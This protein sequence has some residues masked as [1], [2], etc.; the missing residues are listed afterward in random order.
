M[1]K[2]ELKYGSNIIEFTLP[3][4]NLLKIIT[5]KKIN[6][7]FNV[8]EKLLQTLRH[9]I[10]STP[11]AETIKKL[12]LKPHEYIVIILE[13]ITRANPDY[14]Q[15][16]NAIVEEILSSG[17]R[18]EQIKFVIA[19]GTHRA[20]TKEE[21]IKLYG[22]YL[23]NNFEIIQHDPDDKKNLTFIGTLST[24]NKLY[25]NSTVAK[26]KFKIGTGNIE[27]HT[28][29]GYTGGRKC[30]LPGVSARETIARNHSMVKREN[31]ALGELDTN[32]IHCEMMEAA[33]LARLDFIIN[34]IRT[35][36]THEIVDIVSGDIEGAFYEGVK[37]AKEVSTVF[38]SQFA[39]VVITSPG[40]FPR[41]INF[42]Q[43][44]KALSLAAGVVKP[45]GGIILVAECREGIGQEVFANCLMAAKDV[46]EILRKEEKEIDVEEHRA[47]LTA[48]I[49]KR[50]YCISVT[51]LPENVIK[52]LHHEY[53]PTIDDAINKMKEKYGEDFKAYIIPSSSSILPKVKT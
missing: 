16:L 12:S 46:D 11:L 41:D 17:I 7:L 38:V 52:S 8:K 5:P 48:K 22:E 39:D 43:S 6:K 3:E 34:F 44:Q 36:D 49:F 23:V 35:S 1:H 31:V 37:I 47:Y 20:Q 13:D 14:S 33:H 9:P 29:A 2:I 24:G 53:A 28:F 25:I 30:I 32:P 50:N 26:A 42:Y 45:G 21:N 40:G 15:L 4:K 51:S 19:A 27:P 18:K 10:N